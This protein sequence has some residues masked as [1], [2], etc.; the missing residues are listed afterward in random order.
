[1]VPISQRSV[2]SSQFTDP[3]FWIP[4]KRPNA[5]GP[6][7]SG[8]SVKLSG[9]SFSLQ[10]PSKMDPHVNKHPGPAACQFHPLR[11]LPAFALNAPGIFYPGFAGK[12]HTYVGVYACVLSSVRSNSLIR[13][14][15]IR[16]WIF[17]LVFCSF[18]C[19]RFIIFTHLFLIALKLFCRISC[20][21]LRFRFG[22]LLSLFKG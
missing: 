17:F 19:K 18:F 4:D 21:S 10:L 5:G 7:L 6:Q 11:H 22:S 9:G 16:G 2:P 8:L 12:Q 15:L 13:F 1:M 20:R 3:L 14:S